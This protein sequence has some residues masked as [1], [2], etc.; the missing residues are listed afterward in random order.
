VNNWCWGKTSGY[1]IGQYIRGEHELCLFFVR[2][3]I[4]YAKDPL[5][6]KRSQARSLILAD[7]GVHSAKPK[8]IFNRIVRVSPGPYLEMFCREEPFSGW[9]GWGNQTKG[10][11]EIP[12]LNY[13]LDPKK[14]VL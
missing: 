6:G 13:L 1:G 4:P 2:G 14:S 12:S 10:C 7:R 9:D 8:E 3:K 11:V 5:T